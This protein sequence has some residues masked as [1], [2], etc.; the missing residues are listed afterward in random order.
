MRWSYVARMVAPAAIGRMY[1]A[2]IHLRLNRAGAT[3]I[4]YALVAILISITVI[5][6]ATFVGTTISSFFTQVGNGF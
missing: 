2:L 6:W 5:G 4:E 3:S 1:A